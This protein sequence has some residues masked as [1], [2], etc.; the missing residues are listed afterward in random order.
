MYLTDEEFEQL[1][2]EQK[3]LK[4]Q[5]KAAKKIE[6]GEEVGGFMGMIKGIADTL[7]LG[8]FQLP[9]FEKVGKFE[10]FGNF[11]CK[12]LTKQDLST[13]FNEFKQPDNI[14]EIKEKLGCNDQERVAKNPLLGLFNQFLEGVAGAQ[15]MKAT[16][17]DPKKM[18]EYE[19]R[20]AEIN[21]KVAD[22]KNYR[23]AIRVAE[24][25]ATAEAAAK[26]AK[27]RVNKGTNLEG[28]TTQV[29]KGVIHDGKAGEKSQ[30]GPTPP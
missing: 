6:S 7:S 10:G 8:G 26:E 2:K 19:E 18:E 21:E 27:K 4:E 22:E 17:I 16:S 12:L 14:A 15:D 1:K 9:I 24:I 20:L 28:G 23:N 11:V 5:I 3:Q 29:E 13:F 25:K 30:D